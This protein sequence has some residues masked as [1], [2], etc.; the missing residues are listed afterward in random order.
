MRRSRQGESYIPALLPSRAL[1][2][3]SCVCEEPVPPLRRGAADKS[4]G[5][6]VLGAPFTTM[7]VAIN[8]LRSIPSCKLVILPRAVTLI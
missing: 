6:W 7:L 4:G 8:Q 1:R 3:L 5:A 2:R